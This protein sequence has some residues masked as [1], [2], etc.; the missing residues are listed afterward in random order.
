M[1]PNNKT[2]RV[3]LISNSPLY[4]CSLSWASRDISRRAV[5]RIVLTA[6]Y[7]DEYGSSSQNVSH[8]ATTEFSRQSIHEMW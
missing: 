1:F 6:D 2:K 4:G 8:R 3:L 7:A 5:G